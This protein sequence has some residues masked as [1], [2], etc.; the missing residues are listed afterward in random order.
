MA[1]KTAEKDEPKMGTHVLFTRV[2]SCRAF[3]VRAGACWPKEKAGEFLEDILSVGAGVL[4]DS[5]GIVPKGVEVKMKGH[6]TK[7]H[8][9]TTLQGLDGLRGGRK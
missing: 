7:H 6:E 8:D 2:Y 3:L 4:T 5:T 9:S 1:K